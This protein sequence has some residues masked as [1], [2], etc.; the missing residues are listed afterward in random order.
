MYTRSIDCGSMP[1]VKGVQRMYVQDHALVTQVDESGHPNIDGPNV[2]VVSFE[3]RD[4]HSSI[5]NSFDKGD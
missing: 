3:Y 5:L 1:P 2:K 4:A